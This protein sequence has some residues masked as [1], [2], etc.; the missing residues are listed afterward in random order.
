[1]DKGCRGSDLTSQPGSGMFM[2]RKLIFRAVYESIRVSICLQE[3]HPGV[4]LLC[5]A[6]RGAFEQAEG[7]KAGVFCRPLS[8]AE[9]RASGNER[10][11][12]GHGLRT[13]CL[14]HQGS[15]RAER[16]SGRAGE[17]ICE[18]VP[19]ACGSESQ[20]RFENSSG[21]ESCRGG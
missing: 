15:C 8:P 1:M 9:I 18:E 2:A 3:G 11:V 16:V 7:I 6:G 13:R 10:R 12:L 17:G 21:R 4:E 5:A 19:R 20:V 14:Q